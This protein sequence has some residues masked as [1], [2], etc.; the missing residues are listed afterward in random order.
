[1]ARRKRSLR[2]RARALKIPAR[3]A[4]SEEVQARI[5]ELPELTRAETIASYFPL[6]PEPLTSRLAAELSGRR[7]GYPVVRRDGLIFRTAGARP[8]VAGP[9]PGLLEPAEDCPEVRVEEIEVFLIPGL[10]FDRRGY[11]LGRGKGYDRALVRADPAALKIGVCFAECFVEA[12]PSEPTDVK[13]NV[14]ATDRALH[15]LMR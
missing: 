6:P 12:L 1:M 9:Y 3:D 10:F 11:R 4:R 15:R 14:I 13:M 7:L 2:E 8:L 5:L